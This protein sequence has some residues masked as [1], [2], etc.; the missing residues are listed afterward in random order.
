MS[1][2]L[3]TRVR[4]ARNALGLNQR[5]AAKRAGISQSTWQRIEDGKEPTLGQLGAVA[6]ALGRTVESISVSGPVRERLVSVTR[7][8]SRNL[9]ESENQE[10][11]SLH[12]RLD[13]LMEL[14]AH[15]RYTKVGAHA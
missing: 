2:N 15:L 9:S 6:N 12:D 3:A 1:E 5:E 7:L 10:L 11:G 8:K 4:D 14:D 13:Y